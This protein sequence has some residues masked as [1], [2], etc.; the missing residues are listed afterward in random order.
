MSGTEGSYRIAGS[1]LS[2]VSKGHRFSAGPAM[3]TALLAC[4]ALSHAELLCWRN[5][6]PR[7][8]RLDLLSTL[9]AW[10]AMRACDAKL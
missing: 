4:F 10:R 7:R 2:T 8:S 3:R 5:S 6:V 9:P 1:Y